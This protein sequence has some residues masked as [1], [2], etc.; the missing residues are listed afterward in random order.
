MSVVVGAVGWL[1]WGSCVVVT[2]IG[3]G[4]GGRLAGGWLLEGVLI[5][6]E[7]RRCRM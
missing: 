2:A 1:E 4:P 6:G 5:T 3:G 7:V